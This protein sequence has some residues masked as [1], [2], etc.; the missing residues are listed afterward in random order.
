M[1]HA[2]HAERSKSQ[3]PLYQGHPISTAETASTFFET[4]A[5]KRV[6]EMLPEEERVVALHDA[7][8]DEVSTVFRQIACFRFERALH[9]RVR[10]EGYVAKEK[11]ADL[12]NEHVGAYLG[13]AVSLEHEDGYFF[14]HWGH[15]RRFFYVYTYAYGQLISRALHAA[16]EKDPSFIKKVDGFLSAGESL[17]PKDIFK[18][19]GLDTTN[20]AIFRTGLS[21]IEKDVAELERLT[22]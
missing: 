17:S 6:I 2:I 9:E 7:V 1:G 3:R 10:A 12:M 14:A 5:L 11:I 15:I 21:A 16:L 20:P 8:Q 13:K 18:K 22:K 4:A 19:C